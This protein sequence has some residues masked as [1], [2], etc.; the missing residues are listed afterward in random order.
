MPGPI[1]GKLKIDADV[2]FLSKDGE[3]KLGEVTVYVHVKGYA[4]A[5]VTHLDIE[6]E[7]VK[8][9][10]SRGR[11][12]FLDIRGVEGGII[13]QAKM[14]REMEVAGKILKVWGLA[15][16]D[17]DLNTI[18]AVGETTRTWVGRKYDGLY[19]GFRKNEVL[20]LE[21]MALEKFGLRP[22]GHLD[23]SPFDKKA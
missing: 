17:S 5:R 10:I 18:L 3:V 4:R 11:G 8:R 16:F 1:K 21:K 6:D 12:N 15:M 22:L 13:V 2:Y 14:E 7:N 23:E 9:L 19:I 20:K